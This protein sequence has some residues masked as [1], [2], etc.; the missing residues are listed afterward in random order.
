MKK[1]DLFEIL[2]YWIIV[3]VIVGF[4]GWY[5]YHVM[6]SKD[7]MCVAIGKKVYGRPLTWFQCLIL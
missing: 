3:A 1:P 5:F 6:T 7:A 4:C 2:L